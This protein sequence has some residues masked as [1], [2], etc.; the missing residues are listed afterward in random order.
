[1]G[2]LIDTN[3]PNEWFVGFPEGKGE[4]SGEVLFVMY[5]LRTV[6]FG[7]AKRLSLM[8]QEVWVGLGMRDDSKASTAL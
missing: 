8:Y 1:M 3:S 5:S 4:V 2:C 7:F 6:G